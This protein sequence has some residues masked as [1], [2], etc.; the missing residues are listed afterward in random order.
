MPPLVINSYNSSDDESS[1]A[2]ASQDLSENEM[3]DNPQIETCNV[4]KLKITTLVEG[5]QPHSRHV[6][7]VKLRSGKQILP[8]GLI[9]N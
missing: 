1:F 8:R 2:F 6:N 9:T 3:S 5:R 7:Q 4:T